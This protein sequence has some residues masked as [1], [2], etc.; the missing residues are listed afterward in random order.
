MYVPDKYVAT[1]RYVQKKNRDHRNKKYTKT[2]LSMAKLPSPNLAARLG[3]LPRT[4][5]QNCS[6]FSISSSPSPTSSSPSPQV[7]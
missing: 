2:E 3:P 5:R 4:H 6:P 7:V 1:E